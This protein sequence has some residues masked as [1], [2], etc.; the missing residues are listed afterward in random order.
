MQRVFLG[1]FGAMNNE[2]RG[3]VTRQGERVHWFSDVREETEAH[4]FAWAAWV[5]SGSV[6]FSLVKDPKSAELDPEIT[7]ARGLE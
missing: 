3:L 6:G 1:E 5:Y 2:Q 7:T 4:G